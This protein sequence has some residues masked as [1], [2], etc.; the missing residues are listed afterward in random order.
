MNVIFIFFAH[1]HRHFDVLYKGKRFINVGSVGMPLHEERKADFGILSINH[2]TFDYQ[3]YPIPYSYEVL[4]N[5][6][7]ETDYYKTVGN[8]AQI[9]LM[10]LKDNV[11]YTAEVLNYIS[12]LAKQNNIDIRLGIP[13]DLWD[14][15][16]EEYKK[17]RDFNRFV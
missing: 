10:N 12:D 17:I 2:G 13:D 7:K 1:T 5:Y 11:D 16:F 8:F 9:L 15:G 3:A 14:F 6:Y 4:E